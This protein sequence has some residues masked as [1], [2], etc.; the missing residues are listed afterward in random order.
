MAKDV[1]GPRVELITDTELRRFVT[2]LP[3]KH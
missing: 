3:C 1:I 2:K